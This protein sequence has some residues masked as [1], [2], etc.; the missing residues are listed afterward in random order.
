[1]C[2]GLVWPFCR[3]FISGEKKLAAVQG[4]SFQVEQIYRAILCFSDIFLQIQAKRVCF[5]RKMDGNV[6]FYTKKFMDINIFL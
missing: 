5:L 2:F 3:V 6:A 1:L 4:Q